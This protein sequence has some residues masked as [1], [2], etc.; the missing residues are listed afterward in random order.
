MPLSCATGVVCGACNPLVA[1]VPP[2]PT[3]PYEWPTTAWLA[4]FLISL[5]LIL[6]AIFIAFLG[7]LKQRDFYKRDAAARAI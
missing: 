7:Y 5:G 4:P 6:I 1:Y 3:P 2:A